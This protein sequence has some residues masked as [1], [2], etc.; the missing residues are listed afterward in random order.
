MHKRPP[1]AA[2]VPDR[3]TISAAIRKGFGATPIHSRHVEITH[4]GDA[5][6]PGPE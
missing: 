2:S 1:L 3:A 5:K 6:S 4:R